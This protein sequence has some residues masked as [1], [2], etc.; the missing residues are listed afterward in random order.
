MS[1]HRFAMDRRKEADA[2]ASDLLDQTVDSAQPE[3]TP[4]SNSDSIT[5]NTNDSKPP[6]NL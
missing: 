4:H 1:P 5:E 3:S 6:T 2:T